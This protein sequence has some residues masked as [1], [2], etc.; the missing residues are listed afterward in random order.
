M[1]FVAKGEDLELMRRRVGDFI[2]SYQLIERIGAAKT[3]CEMAACY[4][5]DSAA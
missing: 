1:L 3:R 4:F 2:S 5:K